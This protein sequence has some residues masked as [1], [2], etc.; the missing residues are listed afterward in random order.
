MTILTRAVACFSLIIFL[1]AGLPI[2]AFAAGSGA[3]DA[4]TLTTKDT[5]PALTGTASGVSKV[6]ILVE[7]GTGKDMYKSNALKVKDGKWRATVSKKLPVGNYTVTLYGPKGVSKNTLAKKTLS[8]L[9]A[10]GA[11]LAGGTGGSLSVSPILLLTGGNVAHGGS[12]PVA[13]V[14]V[15]NT[16]SASTTINGFTLTENGSAPDD[17]VIGFT[18]NDDKGGSR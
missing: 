12:V 18:T 9:P 2:E 13:Y 15:S 3:I 8:I 14:K 5:T 6:R 10:N 7:N 17:V 11:T 4:S 16:G 1:S